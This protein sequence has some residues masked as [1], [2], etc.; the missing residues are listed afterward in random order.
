MP[1]ID[2]QGITK[3]YG[4]ATVLDGLDLHIRNGE[5]LTLLGASGCG[6]STLLRLLA[7]LDLPDSGDIRRNHQ[8]ILAQTPSE[9]DCAMV[10]QS[11]ALYPHMTVGANICT[12]LLMRQ[13]S[14]W[15]RLPLVRH[16]SP[17]VRRTHTQVEQ[18]G[19]KVA[20]T[21]GIDH[22]WERKPAQLS[23]GQR[24][25][26]ALARAM[27]RSP[28]L[29]LFDEPLSNLDANL[30]QSLRGEIRALHRQLGVTFVYV[31]HDQHEA[32]SMSDR[33]AV[34][35][36]G[37]ILQLDTP[38]AL[39]QRPVS[40]EVAR[41]VGSPRINILS[42]RSLP[43]GTAQATPAPAVEV[44]VRPHQFLWHAASGAWP[45]KVRVQSVEYAGSEKVVAARTASEEEITVVADAM[46]PVREGDATTLYIPPSQAVFFD[47]QGRRVEA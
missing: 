11:Y 12:P 1:H 43:E 36:N 30:R 3:R 39:F 22:L 9:R 47:A 38:E 15:Q 2:I 41:F 31:T 6:K 19:R 4:D 13:L 10:F 23:G 29:F 27:V 26:V 44:G 46:Q 24:Q 45:V 21:L 18:S 40:K 20:Q 16:A 7:G 28:S 8:S 25:R 5:F 34:M 17:A 42:L 33:V 14:F 32:M 35:K 37:R